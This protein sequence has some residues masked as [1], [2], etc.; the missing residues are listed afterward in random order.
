MNIELSDSDM[1][2][3]IRR[4]LRVDRSRQ[5]IIASLQEAIE[6]V[7]DEDSSVLKGECEG[8]PVEY[9]SE[10]FFIAQEFSENQSAF[11]KAVEDALKKL[12]FASI[13]A[14]D[15]YW[16]DHILCKI[17]ALIA[18]TPLGVYELT[19]TQNR[20]VCLE[21]GIALGLRKPYILVKDHNA[22]V[23]SI[24]GGIEYYEINSYL[25]T[26][27]ELGDRVEQ[28]IASISTYSPIQKPITRR[29]DAVVIAHGNREA[30]DNTIAIAQRLAQRG[31]QCLIVGSF[32]NKMSWFL[33]KANIRYSFLE[34]L[35]EIIN[36]VMG[37]RFGV[38]RVGKQVDPNTFVSLG[39]AIAGNRP[40]LLVN[41][42]RDTLPSDL[43]GFGTL[44][45]QGYI[46]LGNK[47]EVYLDPWLDKHGL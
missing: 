22:E 9:Y 28:Y 30:I 19:A 40:R 23:P 31:Y 6:S 18:G 12:G 47:L 15:K 34:T 45:F 11:R 13:R 44:T 24:L 35:E 37:A 8:F 5:L 10:R 42:A 46:D 3:I 27:Y 32:D 2:E 36:G 38:Y 33:D 25:E 14:D 17:L 41:N 16:A 39:I 43:Q 1:L 7:T 29:E 4:Q 20:N 26:A 21:L